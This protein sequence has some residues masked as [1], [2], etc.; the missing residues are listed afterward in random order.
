MSFWVWF[1]PR[2]TF[3]APDD[4]LGLKAD[5]VVD[6]HLCVAK[7]NLVPTGHAAHALVSRLKSG[8][9]VG[10]GAHFP[11]ITNGLSAGHSVP[12]PE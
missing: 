5:D 10:H 8:L 12:L 3:G 4:A 6:T 11:S 9:S 7:S 1:W 2:I